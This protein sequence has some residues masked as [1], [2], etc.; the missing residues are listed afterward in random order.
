MG[1]TSRMIAKPLEPRIVLELL[2][3]TAGIAAFVTLVGG[4][5]LWLRFDGLGLPADRAVSVLPRQML[6]MAGAHALVVP[7]V[8]GLGAVIALY[9]LSGWT[10]AVLDVLAFCV[11]FVVVLV[12]EDAVLDLQIGPGLI[13]PVV[14]AAAFGGLPRGRPTGFVTGSSRPT[15]D[16]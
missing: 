16:R 10:R 9:A 12:F 14:V 11:A 8:A 1:E 4:A 13:A 6:I 2:G 7:A 15:P 3:A 5:L